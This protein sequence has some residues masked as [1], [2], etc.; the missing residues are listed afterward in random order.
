VTRTQWWIVIGLAAA[1][2]LLLVTIVNDNAKR[3]AER[4][5]ED[6]VEAVRTED[7]IDD[8]AC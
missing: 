1:V 7:P 6:C 4:K 8:A 5:A 2:V 3:D